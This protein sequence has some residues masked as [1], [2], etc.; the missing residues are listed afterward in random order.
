MPGVSFVLVLEGIND[1]GGLDRME[2][3]PQDA[4]DSLL[5]QLE[6]DFGQMVLRAHDHG[7]R[8]IGCTLTPFLGSDY[9]HP[10]ARTEAD[11]QRLNEWIKHSG[12]FDGVVDFDAALRDPAS[13]DRLIPAIDF[14]DHLHPGPVDTSA[15][16][17]L[18][19]WNFF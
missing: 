13:S 4:H 18:F 10:S 8:V 14:G 9:Y 15:W 1:L 5:Q 3:H 17:R 16:E 6:E 7:I 11:R 2:E 19:R 12:T